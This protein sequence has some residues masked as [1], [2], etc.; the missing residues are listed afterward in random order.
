MAQYQDTTYCECVPPPICPPPSGNNGGDPLLPT[1]CGELPDPDGGTTGPSGGGGVNPHGGG[2]I[3]NGGDVLPW[4]DP[5]PPPPPPPI[6]P[7]VPPPLLPVWICTGYPP[8]RVCK[9]MSVAQ[10]NLNWP[11]RPMFGTKQ[12]CE[13]ACTNDSIP[14]PPG[15]VPPGGGGGPAAGGN[16]GGTDCHCAWIQTAPSYKFLDN[17]CTQNTYTYKYTCKVKAPNDI[18]QGSAKDPYIKQLNDLRGKPNVTI[19]SYGSRTTA[20]PCKSGNCGGECPDIK[21]IWVVCPGEPTISQPFTPGGSTLSEVEQTE[22]GENTSAGQGASVQTSNN[23][24]SVVVQSNPF[25]PY[26]GGVTRPTVSENN[27]TPTPP[28]NTSTNT[29]L[30][31][32]DIATTNNTP[33]PPLAPVNDLLEPPNISEPTPF[34]EFMQSDPTL[35]MYDK[36]HNIQIESEYVLKYADKRTNKT[37]DTGNIFNSVI[38]TTLN[39]A[40]ASRGGESYIPFNGVTVGALLKQ[41]NLLRQFFT[42]ETQN[43]LDALGEYNLTSLQMPLLM[44]R[45]L[46]R[47]II[48]GTLDQYSPAFIQRMVTSGRTQ[49]PNKLPKIAVQSQAEAAYN[50]VRER[51][52]SLDPSHYR[53]NGNDQQTVRRMRQIPTDIDLTL[54]VIAR[55]G[56]KTGARF[57]NDDGLYI[58]AQDGTVEKPK[59]V[60]EFFGIIRQDGKVDQVR[61]ASNRDIAFILNPADQTVVD[62]LLNIQ[63]N[64][65]VLEVSGP[66]LTNANLGNNVEVSGGGSA[67]PE[68]MLFSSMRET[69]TD[70]PPNNP[71]YRRSSMKYALAW[72]TGDDD[73]KFNDTVKN[74]IGPRATFYIPHDDPIW[75]LILCPDGGAG[76]D[77]FI[78]AIFDSLDI[79]LNDKVYPRRIYT[80]FMLCPT[81]KALYNPLQGASN[82]TTYAVGS[83]VQR[84]I[85]LANAPFSEV[86]NESYTI[87]VRTDTDIDGH[88]NVYGMDWAK[89]FSSGEIQKRVSKNDTSFSS[90]KSIFGKVYSTI[91]SINSN[92]DLR[93]GYKGRRLPQGDVI[94]FLTFNEFVEFL[95]KTPDTIRTNLFQGVYNN[96]KVFPLLKSDT[97]KTYINSDRLTGTSLEASQIQKTTP[98]K[99]YFDPRYKGKLY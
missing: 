39:D 41:N 8:N 4:D 18:G 37:G 30:G 1:V 90:Q 23:T 70:L 13:Q 29:V 12:Q 26:E 84:T 52:Q 66:T 40:I 97:E 82:L 9:K 45:A 77:Y 51:R 65:T 7:P 48:N 62:G 56:K 11:N 71:L 44:E 57:S 75:N 6:V 42:R 99:E 73:T 27:N 83:P 63:E 19:K 50:F 53:S 98:V 22:G 28:N 14:T 32:E 69:L 60:N 15:S 89:N 72:K 3:I 43:S 85:Q 59:Q 93:D 74:Y 67:I 20:N 87:S 31:S 91:D 64:T 61:L 34:V 80:D 92:Y 94:S 68:A 17:G 25:D 16:P 49:F 21:L 5:P 35:N 38:A 24:P 46:R 54:P 88:P 96:I 55:S 76:T 95:S 47:A 81:D 79:P 33:T 78:T 86:N 2:I 58:T 36:E 10:A